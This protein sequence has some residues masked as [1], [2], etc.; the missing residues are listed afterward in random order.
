MYNS[1]MRLAKLGYTEDIAS[2]DAF[3][4]DCFIYISSV[5]DDEAEKPHKKGK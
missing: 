5:I 3:T 2:L 4:A 1:R